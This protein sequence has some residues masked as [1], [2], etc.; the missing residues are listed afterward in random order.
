MKIA[1]VHSFY[2]AGK[3]SGENQLVKDQVRALRTAGHAVE[4]FAAH[5]DELARDPLY[6]LRAAARVASGRGNNPLARLRAYGP[7]VVHVHNLFPNFGRSWVRHWDGP[8]VATLHNYRPMCAAATLYRAGAVCTRCPDGEPWAALKLGCYRGSR[9]ATLPLAWAGRNGPT[10]DPLLARADRIVV[11]SRLSEQTYQRAGVPAERLTLVPNFVDAPQTGEAPGDDTGRW[12]VAARLSAEKGVL[13]LLRQW[14]A[15]EP[16]DIVGDGELLAECRAA[17]PSSVRFLGQVDRTELCR[18]MATWRGL[19][20]PSRWYEVQ[21]C[22]QIEAL[23]AGLPTLAFDGSSVAESVRTHGTGLVTGWDKPLAPVLAEAATLFP[24]LRA[25][26]RQVYAD[27]FTEQAWLSRITT[28]YEEA[29]RIAGGR[30][31]T[32]A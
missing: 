19:V 28:V 3:P 32:T 17:A 15:H 31:L 29:A 26:C 8:L 6:P 1:V 7:E 23:A 2:T 13:E 4:L 24:S 25:H 30:A 20:F 12:L 22:V 16:L 27:H 21:P 11:N 9:A 5:T 10:R 14:P 18:R